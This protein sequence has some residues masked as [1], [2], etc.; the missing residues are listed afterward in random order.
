MTDT[1]DFSDLES[2]EGEV[3]EGTGTTEEATHPVADVIED[4]GDDVV[5]P[6]EDQTS[7]GALVER[8]EKVLSV[9]SEDVAQMVEQRMWHLVYDAESRIPSSNL[10][11]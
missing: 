3:V 6:S 1:F 9:L 11:G 5:E 8:L 10:G 4:Y 7:Y 2:A